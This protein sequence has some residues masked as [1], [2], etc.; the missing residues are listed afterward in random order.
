MT[1]DPSGWSCAISA[2]VHL[3]LMLQSLCNYLP[4][5]PMFLSSFYALMAFHISSLETFRFTGILCCRLPLSRMVLFFGSSSNF[6]CYN[7]VFY[8]QKT[9]EIIRFHRKFRELHHFKLK[10]T[11]MIIQCIRNS[12]GPDFFP[13]RPLNISTKNYMGAQHLILL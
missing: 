5:R 13:K 3:A 12:V 10:L 6:T 11:Q 9:F 2:L 4:A 7:I 8:Q 1:N